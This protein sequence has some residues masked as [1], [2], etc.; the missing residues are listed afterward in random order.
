MENDN[1]YY[2]EIDLKR[3]I[4]KFKPFRPLLGDSSAFRNNKRENK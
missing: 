3:C 2:L 4:N 1:N